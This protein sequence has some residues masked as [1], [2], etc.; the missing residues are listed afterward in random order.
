[1]CFRNNVLYDHHFVSLRSWINK[2]V[3]CVSRSKK[4]DMIRHVFYF[5]STFT[6]DWLWRQV[7]GC[8]GSPIALVPDEGDFP[9]CSGVEELEGF[10]CLFD[11]ESVGDCAF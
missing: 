7:V 4:W 8:A 10:F 9:G 1:M 3:S 2:A 11:S 5:V 6:L